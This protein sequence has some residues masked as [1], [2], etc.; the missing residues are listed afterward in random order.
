MLLPPS[1]ETGSLK[2]RCWP[3]HSPSKPCHLPLPGF[4]WFAG[5]LWFS[6]VLTCITPIL[7]L[8]MAFFLCESL[9]KFTPFNQ[10]TSLIRY[11]PNNVIIIWL[12][13]QRFY[14]QIKSHPEARMYFFREG[15]NLTHRI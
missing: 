1:L 14:C 6:V 8:Y 2:S 9:F 3:G 15:H 5:K 12:N 4:G 13:L 7:H 11:H 10:D